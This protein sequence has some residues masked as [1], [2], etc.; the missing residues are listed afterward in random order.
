MVEDVFVLDIGTRS[1]MALLAHKEEE[2]LCVDQLIY[3]EHKTRSMLDGQIH[4]VEQV[5]G[6]IK[7]LV[8]EMETLSGK[9]LRKVAV[10]AAGRALK[11]ERGLAKIK[12]P[13]NT[14]IT[15][16][17]ALALQ[18]QA[19]QEAQLTLPKSS[20][21]APISQQYYCVGYS[22][23]EERLDNIRLG[24]II[25]QKGQQAEVEVLATFLPRIVI[26]SL[27]TA[28]EKVGL[29]LASITLEPIAV[30]NLVLSPT[31]RRLNLVLV[32]I[33]AGTSDI[34]ICGNNTIHAFGMVPMAGDEVTEKINDHYLLDFNEGERVK[35]QLLSVTGEIEVTDVLGIEQ[36]IS[37]E[38]IHSVIEPVVQDLSQAIVEEIFRLNND[39]PQAI[40]LVGGGSLTPSLSD[41]LAKL[42]ELPNKRVVV[43]M[44]N[45]MQNVQ[46]LPEDMKGPNYIT[47]LGIAYT[48]LNY[49]TLG[50]ITVN[51]NDKKVRLLHLVQNNIAEALLAGGYNIKD[52]YG[53][54]GMA[55]TCEINNQ[56]YTL[57]GKE[58]QSGCIYLNDKEASFSDRIKEGDSIVFIPGKP[59][60]D[61]Y[62]TFRDV[63][64]N[65]DGACTINDKSVN[66]DITLVVNGE[67]KSIEEDIEDGCKATVKASETIRDLLHKAG[68]INN[69]QIIWLNKRAIPLLDIAIIKKNGK[70]AVLTDN[71]A[72]G[73]C[74]IFQYPH[75]LLV[76]DLI[77]KEKA[78][79]IEITING[80]KV[81]FNETEIK[82]N[83]L[84]AIRNTEVIAG[85]RIDYSM[86]VYKA[87]PMLIE[88]FNM[89]DFS[90]QPPPGKTRL[91]ILVN[92]E[93]KG[94]TH[95]IQHGDNIKL[96]WI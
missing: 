96:E 58:G 72:P 22:V 89:I 81:V 91:I 29:E 86:K 80:E 70:K 19:V 28:V 31:M 48:A 82:V 12:Y 65:I 60:E 37:I 73:D 33:G 40:L 53:R 32:D 74:I 7:E 88:I 45:K 62:G 77:P 16:D 87:Q 90:I 20:S 2:R 9:T 47:V 85:D 41:S 84:P 5:A 78:Q 25:G 83:G 17:E 67:I 49:N 24:S 42:L 79:P 26:D 23:V 71:A 39:V 55:L 3:R 50:F 4:D 76:D 21:K 94:Y 63:L 54:P 95:H 51:I 6:L 30:A 13:L 15:K 44:A 52:L 38:E 11:T 59:G 8:L 93:E 34:A 18:L 64:Q 43:Q 14:E 66:L 57:P 75:K 61:A 35:R 27:Q 36:S 69:Q 68:L 56:V 92:N 1:V 46:A 10:A